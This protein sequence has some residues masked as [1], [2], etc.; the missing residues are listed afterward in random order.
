V[1]R[2]RGTA[3]PTKQI[4]TAMFLRCAYLEEVI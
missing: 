4:S 1:K 2:R 3:L